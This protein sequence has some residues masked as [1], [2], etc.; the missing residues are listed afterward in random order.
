MEV[1]P[2]VALVGPGLLHRIARLIKTLVLE[3][4]G[5]RVDGGDSGVDEE[6]RRC[7]PRP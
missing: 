1:Q 3:Q 5:G 7:L 2:T 4:H 6:L